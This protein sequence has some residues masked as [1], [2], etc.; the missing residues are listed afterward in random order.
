MKN[1][2][3]I[4]IKPLSVNEAW[5]GKRFKTPKYGTWRQ[6]CL[7]LL[8]PTLPFNFD[9]LGCEIEV[10]F[11]FGISSKNADLDNLLKTFIDALQLKYGFN[12]K[13]IIKIIAEKTHVQ[14]GEEFIQFEFKEFN[15][16]A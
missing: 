6:N 14:K 8:P 13:K 4:P 3:K 9:P 12:D 1:S 15:E 10:C 2:I 11:L 16:N 5:Q 7:F